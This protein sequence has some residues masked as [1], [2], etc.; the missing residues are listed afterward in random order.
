MVKVDSRG[1]HSQNIPGAPQGFKVCIL[2][3]HIALH[4]S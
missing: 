2:D 4:A 3:F 1:G